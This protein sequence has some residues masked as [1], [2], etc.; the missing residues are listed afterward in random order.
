MQEEFNCPN[1][2]GKLFQMS[3]KRQARSEAGSHLA[4]PII[5]LP[6]YEEV[7]A[8]V[9]KPA[10]RCKDAVAPFIKGYTSNQP[11]T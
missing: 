4:G 8:P 5:S 7:Q 10:T 2:T 11:W 1:E 9:H 6:Y 3:K